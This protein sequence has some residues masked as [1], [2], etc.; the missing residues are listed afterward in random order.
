M[1]IPCW[2]MMPALVAGQHRRLQAGERHAALRDAPRRADGR[3]GLP[4]RRRQPRD[5]DAAARSAT[6]SSRARTSTVISFTG[7]SAT[8]KSIAARPAQRL[9]R[10]SLEL[11]GKNGVVVLRRRGPRPR[12]RTASCGP[13]SGPPASA[14]RRA[15]GSSSSGR[16]SSRC[17]SGSRRARGRCGSAPASTRRSTSARSSTPARSRRSASYIDIGRA[18]GELVIGGAPRDR[19]RPRPRPLL[20]ADDLHRRRCRWTASP[21]R[22]SSGRCSRSSRSTTTARRCSRSTRPATGC[23]RRS[24]RAT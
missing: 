7:S 10:V 6:R 13:R 21:R 24:S 16:S 3:G 4:A 23:R 17:S 22:R 18:E 12:R 1:A 14:A 15:R 5:R 2:K 20:R 8:G 9:K 19:R 11:G